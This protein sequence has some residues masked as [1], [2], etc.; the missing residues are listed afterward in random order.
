MDRTLDYTCTLAPNPVE[1][2]GAPKQRQW[3]RCRHFVNQTSFKC[4]EATKARIGGIKQQRQRQ[5]QQQQQAA[6][7]YKIFMNTTGS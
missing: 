7:A 5:Q 3:Q 1:M 6:V 4:A 2:E